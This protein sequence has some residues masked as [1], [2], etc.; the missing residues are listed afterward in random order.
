MKDLKRSLILFVG[1][2]MTCQWSLS[3]VK[4]RENISEEGYEICMPTDRYREL[5]TAEDSIPEYT[6][7]LMECRN[8]VIVHEGNAGYNYWPVL[9]FLLGLGVGLSG[10]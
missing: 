10:R 3:Y 9:G 1:I 4:T 6:V 5:R 2:T 7:E 8:K